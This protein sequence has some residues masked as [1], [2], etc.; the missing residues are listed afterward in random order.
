M[1]YHLNRLIA[2]NLLQRKRNRYIFNNAPSA[3]PKDLKASFSY[4]VEKPV[5]ESLQ[6]IADVMEKLQQSYKR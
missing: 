5:S 6:N 4:W 2:V 3:E 1:R